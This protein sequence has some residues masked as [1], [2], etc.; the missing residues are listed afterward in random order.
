MPLRGDIQAARGAHRSQHGRDFVRGKAVKKIAISG[1]DVTVDLQLGYPRRASTTSCA[2]SS[3]R[4]RGAAGPQD[5]GQ[6]HAED[7]LA[8]S[9]AGVKLIPASRTSSRR[10]GQGALQVDDAVN[11]A[12]AL[13]PR[14]QGGRA[15]RGHLRAVAA[16][17]AGIA[18]RPSPRTARRSNRSRPTACRRCRSAFS[19]TS[20]RRWSGAGRW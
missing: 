3:R 14:A 11:L 19:S 12:L 1:S 10:I 20:T 2:S 9:A 13:R 17:D 5:H 15:R 8:R 6:R 7:H 4:T 16:D 18:G